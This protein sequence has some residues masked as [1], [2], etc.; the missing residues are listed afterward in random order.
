M[1]Q[2]LGSIANLLFQRLRQIAQLEVDTDTGNGFLLLKGFGNIVHGSEG[3]T[4]DFAI[5]VRQCR[6]ENNRNIRCCLI[7]FQLFANFKAINSRHLH[8]EENQFRGI[9]C[10]FA[11]GIFAIYGHANLPALAS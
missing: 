1:A 4:F 10:D 9:L 7:C 5:G 8:I 11:K 6:H 3:Q 2:G